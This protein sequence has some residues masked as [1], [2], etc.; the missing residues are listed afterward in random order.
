MNEA[1]LISVVMC[2]YNE[3][4]YIRDAIESVLNQTHKDFEFVIWN[5][6]SNDDTEKIIK[7]YKD[8]RIRY[9]Y[10]ENTG[11]GMA[12]RLACQEVRGKYIA[13]MDCDDICMPD[14]LAKQV[15]F[16]E[17][18]PDYVLCSTG[19]YYM[20]ADGNVLGRR[21]PAIK[22]KQIRSRIT[23][24]THPATMFRT[25]AYNKCG[26]YYPLRSAQD[27]IL[28][29]RLL[30][31]GK[32]SNL[33]EA[34][35][36][37]RMVS[38]SVSHVIQDETTYGKMIEQIRSKICADKYYNEDDVDLH[39]QIYALAKKSYKGENKTYIH[40]I[41]IEERIYNLCSKVFSDKT[42]TDIVYAFKNIFLALSK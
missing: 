15:A 27:R 8:D 2:C 41:T 36:K 17:A 30:R 20:D 38:T 7:S 9:F 34:L 28:W 6:G 32:F 25:E 21:F 33:K 23:A 31:E 10:H 3:Q 39:N 22:D 40:A 5:D 1:P 26:G 29:S 18:N 14:R 24:I 42:S 37:Y 4:L 12:L 13:R 16:L 35:L 19:V 11:L